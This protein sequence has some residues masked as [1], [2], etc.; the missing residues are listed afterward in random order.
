MD[1]LMART[2]SKEGSFFKIPSSQSEAMSCVNYKPASSSMRHWQNRRPV[3]I[4][5]EGAK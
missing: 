5:T 3:T 4:T 2:E 1:G